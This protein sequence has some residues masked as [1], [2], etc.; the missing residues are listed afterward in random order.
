MGMDMDRR[1]LGMYSR[2]RR[3]CEAKKET[4][5]NLNSA[6]DRYREGQG[7]TRGQKVTVS[8]SNELSQLTGQEGWTTGQVAQHSTAQNGKRESRSSADAAE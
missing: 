8:L 4:S 6:P 5:T 1:G 3:R 7:R 2:K